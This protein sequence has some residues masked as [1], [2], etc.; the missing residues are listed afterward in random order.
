MGPESKRASVQW[1]HHSSLS[2]KKFK[3]TST[4][5]G[6]KVILTVYWDSKGVL[7]AH[8]Q[9]RGENV[10]SASY[11]EVLSKLRDAIRRKPPGQLTT[12]VLLHD[13][14][15]RPHTA[16][17]TQERIQEL[18]WDLLELPPYSPDLAPSDFYLFGPLKNHLCCKSFPYNEEVETKVQK[19]LRQQSKH[20]YAAGC[21]AL[22][23]QMYQC[24]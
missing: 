19:W 6:G 13:D 12:G 15:A 22:M 7:L 4:P 14:N 21:D 18:E 10:S 17:A 2:T 23:G 8:F 11:C 9:K 1:Q 5:S 3:V 24:W 20:F 16:R